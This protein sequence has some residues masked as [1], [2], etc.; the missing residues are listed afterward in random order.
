MDTRETIFENYFCGHCDKVVQQMHIRFMIALYS[1][2]R[3]KNLHLDNFNTLEIYQYLI[4]IYK[5]KIRSLSYDFSKACVLQHL[6]N[7]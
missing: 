3:R 5:H 7:Q 4:L 6:N 2:T 1:A